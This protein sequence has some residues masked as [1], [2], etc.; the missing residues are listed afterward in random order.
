MEAQPL[1]Y[2]WQE[3]HYK[4]IMLLLQPLGARQVLCQVKGHHS[5]ILECAYVHVGVA[6]G[7]FKGC[8]ALPIIWHCPF[9]RLRPVSLSTLYQISLKIEMEEKR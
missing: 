7:V 2:K 1:F 8:V 9:E 6:S 5:N 4:I 3:R